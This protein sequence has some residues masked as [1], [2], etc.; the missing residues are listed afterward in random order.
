MIYPSNFAE[1]LALIAALIPVFIWA[2]SGLV[3]AR[4]HLKENKQKQW[5]RLHELA[6]ALYNHNHAQGRW[7]QEVAIRE[8]AEFQG[9]HKEAAKQILID[10][11][12]HFGGDARLVTTI[13]ASLIKIG[14]S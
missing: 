1:F 4:V 12:A 2:V 6:S 9:V 7:V 8:L 13:D 11:K 5:R 10:A 14:S 3:S